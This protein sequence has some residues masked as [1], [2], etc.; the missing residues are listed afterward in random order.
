MLCYNK[1]TKRIEG[2]KEIEKFRYFHDHFPHLEIEHLIEHYAVFGGLEKHV[3]LSFSDSLV[4]SVKSNILER[5]DF[6]K[7]KILPPPSFEGGNLRMLRAVAASDGKVINVF[8]RAGLGR[9]EG[10]STYDALYRIGMLYKEESRE[11]LAPAAPG[12]KKRKE[13]RGYTV[14]PK[15]KFTSP[16]YRFWYTFVEPHG[17]EIEK[18]NFE[19]FFES[20]E[21]SFDR[22]VSFTFEDL[23]NALIKRTFETMDPVFEEGNYW[24]RHNE[25]DLMARTRADR[26][27][28]GECKWKGHKICK[29]LVSKLKSK[30]ERSGLKPDYLALFSK[31]GFSNEL[32][33]SNDPQLLCFDLDDFERLL[34]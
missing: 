17:S 24:D 26:M 32:K 18:G 29:S 14:Q 23:S 33:S 8:R 22:Y 30:C 6:L 7:T 4:S 28:V 5:Y 27:I 3:T 12:T 31:S 11:S 15:I 34:A 25:F 21:D 13:E 2:K 19:P 9:S 20:L 16:F 10:Y 1:G